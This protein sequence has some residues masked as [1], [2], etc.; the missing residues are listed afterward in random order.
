MAPARPAAR[1][2][3]APSA[4]RSMSISGRVQTERGLA[5]TGAR[6]CAFA[7]SADCCEAPACT[8]SDARGE[9]LIHLESLRSPTLSASHPSYLPVVERGL[10]ASRAKGLVLTLNEGGASITGSVLDAAGGPIVGAELRATDDHDGLLALGVSAEQGAFQLQVPPGATRVAA[11]ADGYSEELRGVEAPL[12]GLE[13]RLAAASSI[14]GRVIAGDTDEPVGDVLVSARALNE[15]LTVERATQSLEDGTFQLNGLRPGRYSLMATAERWRGEEQEVELELAQA[16]ARVELVVRGA[17]R[18]VGTLQLGGAP[19]AQGLVTLQGPVN[20][21]APSTPEGSV[22]IGALSA[23][24]YQASIACEGARSQETLDIGAEDMH[25]VWNLEAGARVTGVTLS[26]G[27]A[28]VAGLQV[29]V[30]PIGPGAERGGTTCMT[31]EHGRFSCVGLTPGDYEVQLMGVPPRADGVRVHA[32]LESSPEVSLRIHEEAAIHVRIIGPGSFD[33][34]TFSVIASRPNQSA[35]LGQLRGDAFVF[36]HVP[37]GSY[38]VFTDSDPA[39]SA[40]HVTLSRDGE[41]AEI[42]LTLS[43]SHSLRGRVVDASGQAVPDAW[44]HASRE[45]K[46]SFAQSTDPV[47]TDGDGGFLLS[48]LVPGLYTLAASGGRSEGH[49]ER[50]A[51]DST[52]AVVRVQSF[53]SLA[54]RW[55]D[56]QRLAAPNSSN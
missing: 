21:S 30:R 44:V 33:R 19:C 38:D 37:L 16:P 35:L 11:R 6:V 14:V 53:G 4:P 45:Q 56:E 17:A 15:P 54:D 25:R 41:V 27:G 7:P 39:S 52:D 26:A 2:G 31:D 22:T 46:F 29:D 24:L 43:G 48:G 23:G 8:Q 49:I 36:D 13:I 51:S 47:L 55:D 5:I 20:A 18:L 3:E 12:A 10:D 42:R 34:S 28:P 40:E 32:S 50:V 1:A 9:F